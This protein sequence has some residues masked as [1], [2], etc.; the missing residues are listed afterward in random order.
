MSAGDEAINV[1]REHTSNVTSLAVSQRVLYS[2]SLE[3]N[4]IYYRQI[5]DTSASGV[6]CVR[7]DKHSDSIL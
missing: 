5:E 6:E 1:L 2:G 7:V 4:D 3:S